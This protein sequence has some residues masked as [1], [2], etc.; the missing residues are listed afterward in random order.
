[1]N[2]CAY[3][4]MA[5]AMGLLRSDMEALENGYYTGVT[6][7][8]HLNHFIS[9]VHNHGTIYATQTPKLSI[10]TLKSLVGMEFSCLK[11]G[12]NLNQEAL[13]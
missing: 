10:R 7:H 8:S 4:I 2:K 11:C 9:I 3:T 1:M 5:P 13:N 12:K 6:V